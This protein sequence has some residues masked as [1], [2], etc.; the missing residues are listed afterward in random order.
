M[1]SEIKAVL[2]GL[3]KSPGFTLAVACSP[4]TFPPFAQLALIR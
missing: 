1:L 4:V 2:R 3:A